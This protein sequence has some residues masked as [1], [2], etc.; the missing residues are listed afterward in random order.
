MAAKIMYI[1]HIVEFH[2]CGPPGTPLNVLNMSERRV[3]S[4]TVSGNTP[5]GSD[6]AVD[7]YHFGT[8]Y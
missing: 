8:I 2:F 7:F 3:F 1:Q 5:P 4:D 6:T